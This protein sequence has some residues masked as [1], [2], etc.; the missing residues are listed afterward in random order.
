MSEP[1]PPIDDE[2]TELLEA[3]A[4][5]DL[6]PAQQE[7][8]AER[9]AADACARVAFIQATAFD[10]MLSHEFPAPEPYVASSALEIP[11]DL[12][13]MNPWPS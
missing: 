1:V 4:N 8:L 5:R 10:A 2:L 6:T 11:K 12:L 7:R 3:V 13:T 9:L